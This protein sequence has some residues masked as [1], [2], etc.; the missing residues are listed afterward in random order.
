MD[1]QSHA[2]TIGYED[3]WILGGARTPFADYNGTLRDVSA[4]D[5]GIKAAREALKT[6]GVSVEAIDAVVASSVAQ[7]SFDAFFLPRHIGLYSGL[8]IGV[9]ALLVQR[10]CT[11]GFEAVLQAADQ[12]ALGK[13]EA[14][15]CV[16]TESMSRNP[17]ASYSHRGG[18]KMGQVEFKDFLWEATLDTAPRSRMGDTAEELAK[19]YQI[20][21]EDT[22]VFAAT[23]FARAVAAQ[24]AGFFSGEVVPVTAEKFE[25]ERYQT[26]EIR[27]PRNVKSLASDEHPRPTPI[28]ALKSLKPAFKGVQTGGNSSAIVDGAAAVVV[29][30]GAFAKKAGAVPLARV[31]AGA[32]VGVP[33]EI[34]GIGPAP[35]IRAVVAE[36]GLKLD[37]I[38]RFEINE[39]FGAQYI[40]VERELGLDR[41]RVNVNGGAIAIGHPLGATG[42]RCTHTLARE[43]K[44]CRGRY[45]IAT[46]CAGGGQGVA[47]LIENTDAAAA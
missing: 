45:G 11:S 15:L 32:T 9:P 22:D 29:A 38:S 17:I 12:M 35:A 28:E 25:R 2:Q 31:V 13:S 10:L 24:E 39:A 36:A 43:L 19:R 16:G 18:F 1:E 46:A 37:D 21:R 23:S 27:L 20:T 30:S 40:A 34:M 4:T 33:P 42:V 8:P 7:T 6:T 26:R 5:L 14:V 3:V 47:I 44:R 41:E